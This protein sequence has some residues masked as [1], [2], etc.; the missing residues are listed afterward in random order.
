MNKQ[1]EIHPFGFWPSPI[2][3]AS[4]AQG[5]LRFGRVQV[6]DGAVYWSEGRPAERGR[7]QIMRWTEREG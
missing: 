4:V 6:A 3:A 2:S 5:A 7:T 1:R